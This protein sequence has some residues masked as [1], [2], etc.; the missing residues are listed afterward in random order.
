MTTPDKAVEIKAAI[1]ALFAFV[2][3]LVGWIGWAI[4]IWL[5]CM[6]LDYATGTWAAKKNGEWL[7][8]RARE[9]LWHKLGEIAAVLTAALCDIALGVIV[10]GS[11]IELPFEYTT[12]ATPI[13]LLWYIVTELGSI[14]ENAAAMGAPVPNW[15][16]RSLAKIKSSVD[17]RGEEIDDD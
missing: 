2:T 4:L 12:L 1:A 11:G 7:S 3:A 16:K 13:V 15:L 14:V 8:A 17:A 9:G 10:Q 5:A 6:L